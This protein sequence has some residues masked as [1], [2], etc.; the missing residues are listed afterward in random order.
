MKIY[1]KKYKLQIWQYNIYHINIITI[2][3]VIILEKVKEKKSY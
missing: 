3:D 2:K 1:K